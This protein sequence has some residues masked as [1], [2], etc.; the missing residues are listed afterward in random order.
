MIL[1]VMILTILLAP[2]AHASSVTVS[3]TPTNQPVPQG[4]SASYAVN[5]AG[6]LAT[7]YSLTLS[8]LTGAG[9]SFS[10]N[11]VSTPPGGGTGAGS[12]TL[13]I[14]TS[15]APGLYCPG[16]YSF[17]VTATNVTDGT[18][19]PPGSQPPG[20]PN[21]DTA[22]ASG[23]I[24]VVQVGP[25]LSVNVATDKSSY[26][27]G[28][29]VTILLSANR[30]A[31]GQLTISPPSGP[32]QIFPYSFFYGSSYSTSKTLTASGIGHWTVTLQ[33]DDFCS[34][35][36]SA[37]TSFDVSPNTYDVSVS[38]NGVPTQ[39]SAQLQ[40]D[41]QPQGTIGG[42]EIKSMSFKINTSHTVS[43]DQYVSGDAGVRFYCAQNT[44]SIS[45]AGSLTFNY[46]TQFQFTVA[47]NPT[48]VAQV[49]GGG[50]FPSGTTV[51]TSQAQ[52][53][54]AGSAGT[55][56]AFKGWQINGVAQS[57]N[58]VTLTIDKPYTAIAQ[59]TTQYQL[60][61]NSAY[62]NPQGAG[63]YDSGSTAQFSVT[64]PVGFP[65]QQIFV[66]WQGDYNGTSPQGQITMDKPHVVQA[67]WSTSYLP[68][69]VIVVVAA[70]IVGGLLF[71]RSR[72]GG[73][74]LETKPTPSP[75]GEASTQQQTGTQQATVL[76]CAKCGGE[77]GAD[78]RFCTN[79]GETLTTT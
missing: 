57:G 50:W 69:I 39:Y 34:G 67:V 45:S 49:S 66:Q 31:E 13:S 3:I 29:K 22:S 47:T 40:V 5:L 51:Q 1:G 15:S 76:K 27:V 25:P 55:Q 72:R 32:P 4:T 43:V 12:T 9:A 21:P 8:G 38:L 44:M 68:L 41:G 63:Y 60:V 19:P 65:I 70:A 74:P 46:Q 77:N 6:A 24:T 11:P 61:V 71:W 79:C 17:T 73:G 28:D 56:F 36:S 48:G 35:V 64:T 59:Y 7:S 42:G 75:P 33:A 14:P 23:S 53:S 52:Q 16:T 58:P 10:S 20:Y 37:Q 62:G 18:V 26:T 54:V 2:S 30:P 78:Q